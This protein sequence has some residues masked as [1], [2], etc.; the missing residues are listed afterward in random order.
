MDMAIPAGPPAAQHFFEEG[1]TAISHYFIMDWASLW[2]DILIGIF[3]ASAIAMWVPSSFWTSRFF[4]TSHPLLA[5]FWEP[6]I[7]PSWRWRLSSAPSATYLWRQ[8]SGTTAS[9]SAA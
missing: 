3:L 9:A 1:K 5:K 2:K 7:G 6:V 8:C 4:L